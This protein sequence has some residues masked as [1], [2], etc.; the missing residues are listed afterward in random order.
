MSDAPESQPTDEGGGDGGEN[1]FQINANDVIERMKEAAEVTKDT[2]LAKLLGLPK[3][4]LSSWRQRNSVPYAECVR[5]SYMERV[6]IDW[7]LTGRDETPTPGLY[8]GPIDTEL[9]SVLLYDV[10]SRQ[11]GSS[12][13]DD[14]ERAR[15]MARYLVQSYNRQ[16]AVLDETTRL[17]GVPQKALLDHLR[18]SIEAELMRD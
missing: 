14:F 17:H 10:L 5:M 13:A 3:T 9:L 6:S 2:D 8:D 7:L 18:R 4:T 11:I 15:F 1:E 12:I 16:K